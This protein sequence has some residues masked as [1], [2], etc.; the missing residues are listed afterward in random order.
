MHC[1]SRGTVGSNIGWTLL[2]RKDTRLAQS[3]STSEQ[4]RVWR[5]RRGGFMLP[6]LAVNDNDMLLCTLQGLTG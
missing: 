5:E 1:S 2:S 4:R 3:T 6:Q